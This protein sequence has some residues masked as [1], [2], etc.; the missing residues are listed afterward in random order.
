MYNMDVFRE[1]VVTETS[2][3]SKEEDESEQLEDDNALW[4]YT[5]LVGGSVVM[6]CCVLLV[7]MA[8]MVWRTKKAR[9][10]DSERV[11]QIVMDSEK[12]KERQP[13]DDRHSV[14]VS[15][16]T[17]ETKSASNGLGEE[18]AHHTQGHD[19]EGH[20]NEVDVN[21]E[22]VRRWLGETVGLP[23]YHLH[24]IQSGYESLDFIKAISSIDELEEI[25]IITK[26][27]QIRLRE[28]INRLKE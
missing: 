16:Q 12:Q 5:V 4:F 25:G 27:H 17:P 15:E 10:K 1:M 26:V 24:F 13:K 18:G 23:Q 9:G 14:E 2:A 21:K 22:M 3:V 20:E 28:H 8:A 7:C 11:I 19:A 6:L